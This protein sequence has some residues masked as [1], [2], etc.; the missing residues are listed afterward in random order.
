MQ[1]T[2]TSSEDFIVWQKADAFI[3]LMHVARA[4]VDVYRY[5]LI[6]S[7]DLGYGFLAKPKSLLERV[8]RL[9]QT[10]TKQIPRTS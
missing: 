1:A 3:L 9:L 7:H 8:S 10:N 4:S 5:F 6:R 2:T